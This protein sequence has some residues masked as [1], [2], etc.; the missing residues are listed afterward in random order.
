VNEDLRLAAL[1]VL[2]S[3]VLV[4]CGGSSG[5]SASAPSPSTAAYVIDDVQPS[6][7]GVGSSAGASNVYGD[8]M[9]VPP[10][11]GVTAVNKLFVFLP[12][13]DGSPSLYMDILEE[14]SS[15]GYHALGLAY[16]N[17][18]PI[19]VTCNSSMDPNCF[20]DVR[21]AVVTG[22]FSQDTAI[23]LKDSIVVRLQNTLA[24]LSTNSAYSAQGWGQY[25]NTDGSV[26][27]SLVVI[28]GHSQG[29]GHAAVIAKN[30]AVMRAC[31]FASPPDWNTGN[32]TPLN[33]PAAWE[34]PTNASYPH[35]TPASAQFG[36]AGLNDTS[37]PWTSGVS[38]A[39]TTIQLQVIWQ[40]M[41]LAAFGS[42]AL[43]N[44]TSSTVPNTGTHE[45]TTDA[46]PTDSNAT[47]TP[48]HGVT[49]RDAFTPI[50]PATN[51]PLF[52]PAWDYL[53]FPTQ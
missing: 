16:P 39:T 46:T 17:S 7:T 1:A 49:V 43:I 2:W 24:Y 35:M 32:Q 47:G 38:G 44:L 12:G 18:P 37:V 11:A 48:T 51:L 19:G 21:M 25:L 20:W 29:G 41:G 52:A 4:G 27:W 42:P 31:Y 14:G 30:Y 26:N 10:L 15:R 8:H 22:S 13:S 6:L 34:D 3:L 23:A 36:F 33:R 53:C 5:S 40:T 9:A 28:A 45:L 50:N